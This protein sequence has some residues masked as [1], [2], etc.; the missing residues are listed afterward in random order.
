MKSNTRQGK[1][2]P[3]E[4]EGMGRRQRGKKSVRGQNVNQAEE[5]GSGFLASEPHTQQ[6]GGGRAK[7]N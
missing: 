2:S 1:G 6:E 7:H 5:G 3:V 4:R